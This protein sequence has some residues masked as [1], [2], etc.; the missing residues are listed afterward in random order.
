M[1]K[2]YGLESSK[3]NEL[4]IMSIVKSIQI[5]LKIVSMIRKYHNHKPQTTPWH[6]HQ[7]KNVPLL[8]GKGAEGAWTMNIGI[9][10]PD[11]SPIIY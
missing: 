11:H 1:N 6:P 7:N 9:L 10:I 2:K 5:W 8:F 4:F 3:P